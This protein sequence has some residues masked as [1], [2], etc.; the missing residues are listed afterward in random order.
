[1]AI[2]S[3][4][5]ALLSAQGPRLL[6]LFTAFTSAR[7]EG[8]REISESG[9]LTERLCLSAGLLALCSVATIA[10]SS[11]NLIDATPDFVKIGRAGALA[12]VI[13]M[14]LSLP[15]YLALRFLMR[16]PALFYFANLSMV[17]ATVMT[18]F[19]TLVILLGIYASPGYQGDLARLNDRQAHGTPLHEFI[20]G[21]L[22]TTARVVENTEQQREV[23]E[24]MENNSALLEKNGLVLER[25]SAAMAAFLAKWES[26]A[27]TPENFAAARSE[28]DP[29]AVEGM[30]AFE[31]GLTL[32]EE[33]LKI[34]GES[35]A[36]IETALSLQ[37]GQIAPE[38]RLARGY[39]V[40]AGFFAAGVLLGL[41]VWG[42]AI[43]MTASVVAAGYSS[44]TAK[45]GAAFAVVAIGALIAVS[46]GTIRTGIVEGALMTAPTEAQTLA[47]LKYAFAKVEPTC[48]KLD[49]R[50]LW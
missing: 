35:L 2:D 33:G 41:A 40:L 18:V 44:K 1:M 46:F 28:G 6:A 5:K 7:G 29:I 30:E 49:N 14:L 12:A 34:Q 38:F 15:A 8:F 10:I 20:C 4:V 45:L 26:R 16:R 31:R 25:Q 43:V 36:L 24:R 39:P 9:T 42:V 27:R 22:E 17:S 48:G 23:M 21:R 3:D 11:L 32:R 50:G 13:A 19:T 47:E 37:R